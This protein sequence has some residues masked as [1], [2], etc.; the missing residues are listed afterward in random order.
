MSVCRFSRSTSCRPCLTSSMALSY[1]I[2]SGS[3]LFS[4]LVDLLTLFF[5]WKICASLCVALSRKIP[6]ITN[7]V[8]RLTA[9]KNEVPSKLH[10]SLESGIPRRSLP[11]P[12]DTSQIPAAWNARLYTE[13]KARPTT[14]LP[15]RPG[16]AQSHVSVMPSGAA[17]GCLS[18]MPA[19]SLAAFF[20]QC[21]ITRL[22]LKVNC[23][24][25]N[26]QRQFSKQGIFCAI[27]WYYFQQAV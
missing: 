3:A 21:A 25:S 23:S 20:P 1:R 11:K 9:A 8:G 6:A 19:L 17:E 24:L 15:L 26:G 22:P 7:R 13:R 27:P 12:G 10:L 16:L 18:L 4:A 14:T 2:L 5:L